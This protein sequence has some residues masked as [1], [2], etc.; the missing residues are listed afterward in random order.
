MNDLNEIHKLLGLIYHEKL[1][2]ISELIKDKDSK[3]IDQIINLRDLNTI[4]KF[5]LDNKIVQKEENTSENEPDE[6]QKEIDKIK[7]KLKL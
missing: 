3:E 5:L 2:A 7:N 6:Y 1:K 4:N